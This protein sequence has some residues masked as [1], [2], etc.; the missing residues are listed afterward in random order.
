MTSDNPHRGLALAISIASASTLLST[1]GLSIAQTT[2]GLDAN[3][4]LQAVA[5]PGPGF[6]HTRLANG[7]QIVVGAG[8]VMK[9]FEDALV[10]AKA[11]DNREFQATFAADH[12]NP[13]LAGKQATFGFLVG[14]AMKASGGKANPKVVSDLLRTALN[15]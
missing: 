10:G 11:G 13:K 2:T 7:V 5:R 3:G 8:R 6:S 12:S 4:G 14:Q 1:P 15:R 9:E